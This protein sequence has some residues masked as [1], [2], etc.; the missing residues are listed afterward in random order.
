LTW[1][2]EER[3]RRRMRKGHRVPVALGTVGL[4]DVEDTFIR[5]N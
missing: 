2:V 5:F 3:R 1:T 4:G